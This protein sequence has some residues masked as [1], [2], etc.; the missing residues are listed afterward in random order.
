MGE[1]LGRKPGNAV[2]YGSVVTGYYPA[3]LMAGIPLT[4]CAEYFCI[5]DSINEEEVTNPN[6]IPRPVPIESPLGKAVMGAYARDV[7]SVEVSDDTTRKF[8]I[9]TVSNG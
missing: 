2:G 8:K 4:D 6:R 5:T 7:V 3:Q 9:D 1:Q